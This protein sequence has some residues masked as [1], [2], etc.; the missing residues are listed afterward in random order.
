VT[1]QLT[2]LQLTVTVV[3]TVTVEYSNDRVQNM[4][5]DSFSRINATI[6]KIKIKH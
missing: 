6:N 5:G 4:I 3:A 2:D 1:V